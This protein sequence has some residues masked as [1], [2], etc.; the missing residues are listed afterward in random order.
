MVDPAIGEAGDIDTTMITLRYTN[1]VL[2]SIDNSRRAVYG[3]DQRVEVF[4]SA[5]MAAS[6][7]HQS[8]TTV[9][10]D[11]GGAHG[12][13]VP[14]FF[15]DRYV[16]SYIAEWEAFRDMARTGSPSPV[17]MAD[18]RAPLALGIAALRSAREGRIVLVS[19]VG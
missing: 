12:A 9:F 13:T 10:R 6:E 15:L 18:G 7:N 5:G 17:S 1:G 3:Y 11:A 8:H 2:G 4:G 19:E 16:P 14:Y